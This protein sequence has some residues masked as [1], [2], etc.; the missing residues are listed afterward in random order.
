MAILLCSCTDAAVKNNNGANNGTGESEPAI[1]EEALPSDSEPAPADNTDPSEEPTAL[2]VTDDP[3]KGEDTYWSDFYE[4]LRSRPEGKEVTIFADNT[5]DCDYSDYKEIGYDFWDLHRSVMAPKDWNGFRFAPKCD[6]GGEQFEN[7]LTGIPIYD[8]PLPVE[9]DR[10]HSEHDD[11]TAYFANKP[12]EKS[13]FF[14][15]ESPWMNP[16][17]LIEEYITK[18]D[19]ETYIDKKGRSMQVYYL[20]G[21]PKYACYD[22]FFFLCIW[23]NLT[24]KE[25]IPTVVNMINSIEVSL[26]DDAEFA[27]IKAKMLGFT[28]IPPEDY[29]DKYLRFAD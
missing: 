4:D 26:S 27:L 28:I 2:T 23:F 29:C 21:L 1:S 14:F 19:H 13:I 6:Y 9:I 20:D 11:Y 7:G 17:Q 25:Q 8:G 3:E 15:A 22:D 24:S 18:Y 16:R 5:F 10:M 12:M